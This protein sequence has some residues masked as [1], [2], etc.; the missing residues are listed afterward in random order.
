M[1][2]LENLVVNTSVDVVGE[3]LAIDTI[4]FIAVI[5]D[6]DESFRSQTYATPI[7]YYE[8]ITPRG[9]FYLKQITRVGRERYKV[10]GI[11]L[12]GLLDN[13][14][15][16]GGYY[17]GDTFS[18]IL[19]ELLISNGLER[20]TGYYEKITTGAYSGNIGAATG[21][22]KSQTTNVGMR[23]FHSATMH[24][25]M[26]AK[27]TL[28]GFTGPASGTSRYCRLVGMSNDST[29]Y[30]SG[31]YKYKLN[32][33]LYMY[34]TRSNESSPWP[35]FGTVY[36]QY[37]GTRISLGTPTAGTTYTID[38]D[39]VAGRATIN[40]TNYTITD[41]DENQ[42][43]P[44]HCGIGGVEVSYVLKVVSGSIT[45]TTEIQGNVYAHCCNCDWEYYRIYD[46]NDNILT[47]IKFIQ[48]YFVSSGSYSVYD[49]GAIRTRSIN[50]NTPVTAD[51]N[52]FVTYTGNPAFFEPSQEMLNLYSNITY[53]AGIDTILIYGRLPIL[54]KRDALHQLLFASGVNLVK[55]ADGNLTFTAPQKVSVGTLLAD[56]IYDNGSVEYPEHV[57][58]IE[59]DE[60]SFLQGSKQ[61]LFE[62]TTAPNGFYIARYDDPG[63]RYTSVDDT[64]IQEVIVGWNAAVVHG[65]GALVGYAVEEETRTVTKTI[66]DYPDGKTIKA[67]SCKLI[68]VHNSENILDKLASYYG[69]AKKIKMSLV[70]DGERCGSYY[71]FP[72]PFN[73]NESGFLTKSSLNASVVSKS[74]CEFIAG[75]NPPNAGATYN[76]Y[77]IL[78]ESGTWT[79]PA[80]V[81]L[82]D[83]PKIHLVIIGG[84]NGGDGGRAGED[85]PVPTS[86]TV[87]TGAAGGQ[88]GNPGDGGKIFEV[89][90]NNPPATITYACGTGGSGGAA[91]TSTSV[92]NPG[93]QGSD[94]TVTAGGTTYTSADGSR[95]TNGITNSITRD[96]YGKKPALSKWGTNDDIM[97]YSPGYG[98]GGGG[99]YSTYTGSQLNQV[100]GGSSQTYFS[101]LGQ[102]ASI[103]GDWGY[104]NPKTGTASRT[105]G[106]GGGGG[107]GEPGQDGGDATSSKAGKG[108]NGGN[109]I[110]TPPKPTVYNETYYGWGG[111]GGGG[112][113]G[114]GAAGLPATSGQKNT[115]GLGGFGGEGGDGAD[116]IVLVYY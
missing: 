95:I 113:G 23:L 35:A 94:T 97:G 37:G 76:N 26:Q 44:L 69:E 18:E 104:N 17:D 3:E 101:A 100:V 8:G 72:N 48:S 115:G 109:A 68:G 16:Y 11:S 80:E 66:A 28:N 55:T 75:Y 58:T 91:S 25:K 92:S 19:R 32:Y 79:V 9:K 116:G 114:G 90:I 1:D 12:I 6:S 96:V 108:G 10:E 62:A 34:V 4:E 30:E 61:T 98:N 41:S 110:Y 51:P 82:K 59:V 54:T 45:E 70:S 60:Y 24:S 93:S 29:H 33:G 111:F 77:E 112:G 38:V 86:W 87:V 81:F 20:F 14:T 107:F 31:S 63:L 88:A 56:N 102:A 50:A 47:D 84:G 43:V 74:D 71:T 52:S 36:F 13:E 22:S 42:L 57:N 27:F 78:S 65:T 21:T 99:G 5:D 73:E 106:G 64:S 67:N 49:M 15:F 83:D 103:G 89:T 7:F 39:P 85:G 46:Q 105:G 2:T 53:E 40:G